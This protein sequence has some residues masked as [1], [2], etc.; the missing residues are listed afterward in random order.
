M[1]EFR[2]NGD[3]YQEAPRRLQEAN[4]IAMEDLPHIPLHF[5]TDI[6]AVSDRIEW[7]PRRDTQVRG[8]DI[9]L[10]N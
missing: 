10:K 3:L 2:L 8:V 7:Q 9:R 6:Y 5:Q 1:S 4:R